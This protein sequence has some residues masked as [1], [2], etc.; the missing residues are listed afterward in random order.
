MSI[1]HAV[2]SCILGA[3][4]GAALACGSAFAADP[5]ASGAKSSPALVVFM[6]KYGSVKS[7]AAAERFNR[8]AELRGLDV[9]AVSRAPNTTVKHDKVPQKV[10]YEL[11]LEGYDITK[12]PDP[13]ALTPEEAARAVR[14]VQIDV[15]NDDAKADA[16]P[17]EVTEL[18]RGRIERWDDVPPMTNNW[19]NARAKLIPRV[20]A[21][22]DEF[23]KNPELARK[24]L[25]EATK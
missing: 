12:I 19:H 18:T 16:M 6:C 23:M 2:T 14:V 21:I 13:A 1:Y 22:F 10:L 17:K 11:S 15:S 8:L 20:D 5:P 7:L 25:T 9:R 24:Q 3:G 4:L